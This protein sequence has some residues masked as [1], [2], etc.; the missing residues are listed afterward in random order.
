MSPPLLQPACGS[1]C[2]ASE[3]RVLTE[4][5]AVRLERLFGNAAGPSAAEAL[6]DSATVVPSREVPADVVTMYSTVV[7][8]GTEAGDAAARQ[9]TLCYPPDAD[10]ARGR[11]SVLS[12]LGLAL[13]G[14]RVGDAALWQTP[15]GER[16]GARVAALI[17]QPEASGDYTR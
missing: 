17:Y 6:T 4:L 16:R 1:R 14:L 13:L 7:L 8:E 12:P 5:D 11:V 2:F 15:H 3:D 9:I 10:P